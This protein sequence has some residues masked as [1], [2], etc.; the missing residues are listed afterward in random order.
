MAARKHKPSKWKKTG[1]STIPWHKDPALLARVE[2]VNRMRL[3]GISLYDIAE[4][5]ECDPR[6]V[7]RDLRRMQDLLIDERKA[8]MRIIQ[9]EAISR[10]REVQRRA[11][12]IYNKAD[13]HKTK[14]GALKEYREAQARVDAL[15]GAAAP[16]KLD[17]TT[18]GAKITDIKL[19]TEK[20][21]EAI[22]AG[23]LPDD[24]NS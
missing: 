8:D 16:V 15:T 1:R 23:V 4:R 22:A 17:H 13:D 2:A 12:D 11:M 14:L 5:L 20:E 7:Q 3:E 24:S 18:K 9:D 19:M 21:L 6:T 10:Y